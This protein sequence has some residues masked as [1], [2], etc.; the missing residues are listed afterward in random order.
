MLG[1]VFLKGNNIE[2]IKMVFTSFS[3]PIQISS[4]ESFTLI[5]LKFLESFSYS[6]YV[7]LWNTHILQDLI[8]YVRYK[9]FGELLLVE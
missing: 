7:T 6:N 3:I 1:E 8:S 5:L 9:I 4:W 2:K